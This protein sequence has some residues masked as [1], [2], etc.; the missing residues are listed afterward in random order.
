MAQCRPLSFGERK[1]GWNE[2]ILQPP[3]SSYPTTSKVY[4]YS[5]RSRGGFLINFLC[6]R[7]FLAKKEEVAN[8][9]PPT[10][11]STREE[12]SYIIVLGI[13]VDRRRD[14]FLSSRPG[15]LILLSL[16]RM[17][18]DGAKNFLFLYGVM[19]KC[20]IRRLTKA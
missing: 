10:Q 7:F 20:F 15:G 11:T 8:T 14:F 19:Q 3:P 16:S 13:K 6:P 18:R 12:P 2:L 9:L 17:R 4:T 5:R 1:R